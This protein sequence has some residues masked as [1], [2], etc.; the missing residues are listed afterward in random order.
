MNMLVFVS[1]HCPHCPAAERVAE[2]VAPQYH[3]YG[4]RYRKI[5]AKTSE[6]K[7]L[8]SRYNVMSTPTILLVDDW[9]E[10]KRIT[11]TPSESNLK[12]TVEKALGLRKSFFGKL[13]GG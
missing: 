3:D 11:G 2:K 12:G 8:F 10:V 13:F 1:S 9:K 6:G 5:R 4:L 7:E